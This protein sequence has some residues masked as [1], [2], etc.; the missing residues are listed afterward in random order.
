MLCYIRDP[1]V[2]FLNR[3]D[4]AIK[5]TGSEDDYNNFADTFNCYF[6][7]KNAIFLYSPEFYELDKINK[8]KIE[9]NKYYGDIFLPIK[10]NKLISAWSLPEIQTKDGWDEWLYNIR[11]ENLKESPSRALR[12]CA[13]ISSRYPHICDELIYPAFSSCYSILSEKEKRSLIVNI[14][15]VIDSD[16]LPIKIISLITNLSEYLENDQLNIQIKKRKLSD[17]CKKSNSL[18]RSLRYKEL[19]YLSK[20]I[21]GKLEK[22]IVYELL[23]LNYKLEQ[24][25]EAKGII[26][27]LNKIE[28]T[29]HKDTDSL[30]RLSSWDENI[31]E[32]GEAALVQSSE[33]HSTLQENFS[34][35]MIDINIVNGVKK[36]LDEEL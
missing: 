17:L 12:A 29:L 26:S 11:Q 10:P 20:K 5:D 22:S 2:P 32:I 30:A 31:F 23:Q 1:F 7:D 3:V 19:E 21:N 35:D 9:A 18:A 13:T 28:P 16:N 27:I 25:D 4:Q 14:I 36:I 8:E 34:S 33:Y 24:K 15:N 6:Q